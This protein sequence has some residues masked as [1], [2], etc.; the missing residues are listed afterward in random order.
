MA[1]GTFLYCLAQGVRNTADCLSEE[2][3]AGTLGLLFLTDLR[4]YDVVLG[5]LMATSLNSFYGLLA[6]FPPLAIP[7]VIGGVTVGEFWRL[8]LVLMNTLFFSVAV[9]LAV[10][11][12]SRDE[13]RAWSATVGLIVLFAAVPPLLS[14]KASWASSVLAALSP[15]TGFLNVFDA[16]YSTTP[17]RYWRSFQCVQMLSWSFL[18]VAVLVLP[19]AWQDRPLAATGSWWR[20]MT[21]AGS[22]PA[23]VEDFASRSLLLDGNPIVWLVTRGRGQQTA[24]WLLVTTAAAV[25]TFAWLLASGAMPVATVVF[26]VMFLVHLTVAIWVASEACHAFAGARDSGALELLLC[27]PLSAKEV[28]EGHILGLRRMFYQPVA[29]LLSVEGLL[30]GAQ[31]LVMGLGG[32]PFYECALVVFVVALC[33]GAAVLDLAA[34]ARYGLWQGLVQRKPAKAINRTVL[35]VLVVPFAVSLICTGGMLLP[36]IWPLKNLVFINYARDQMRRQ[37]RALLTER[38]GWA[39]QSEMVGQPAPRARAHQLPPVLPR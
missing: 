2:K 31:A 30:I 19:R 3:R 15:T 28:V 14:L 22:P 5:K 7:L 26:G 37:F 36:L 25:A 29:V 39:E 33:L 9:G 8:V 23:V 34:V 4:P 27:T 24:L 20:R 12:A 35:L 32:R 10:S 17:D 1:W 11:A 13:R 38:Y 16:A 21:G 18:L 6:I